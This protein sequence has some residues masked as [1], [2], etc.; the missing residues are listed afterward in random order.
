MSIGVA[1]G[2]RVAGAVDRPAPALCTWLP[3]L[4]MTLLFASPSGAQSWPLDSALAR[5]DSCV[6]VVWTPDERNVNIAW[7][8][9]CGT[10]CTGGDSVYRHCDFL[11]G[12]EYRG[13]AYS[14]GGEDPYDLFAARVDSGFPVG[15]HLCHYQTCGDPSG[16]A[17]GTD[18]SAFLCYVWN[19]PRVSTRVLINDSRLERIERSK[20]RAGDALV[21]ASAACGYHAIFVAEALD[22]TEAVLWE[23]SSSVFG[24]RERVADITTAAWD[25]YTALRYPALRDG[26][27]AQVRWS[28]SLS[29][30]DAAPVRGALYDL[31]GR[32]VTRIPHEVS[33][34]Q[35]KQRGLRIFRADARSKAMRILVGK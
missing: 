35:E 28:N 21:K 16:K 29:L 2:N 7:Y 10:G 4:L 20:V 5:G 18:C 13:V 17:T 25:C 8:R 6:N 34:N 30:S 11:A 3:V 23:A 14:Y 15:S 1:G 19:I 12:R 24:C 9:T 26:D 32:S 27:V 22:P 31:M 33:E